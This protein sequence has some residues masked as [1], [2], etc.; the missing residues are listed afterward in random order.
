MYKLYNQAKELLEQEY[1]KNFQIV[2]ESD[3]H[4][5][6]INEKIRH[7]LQ[8]SGAG[9]GILRHEAYFQNR[10][11]EFL[12]ICRSAIVLHDIFRFSE[13]SRWFLSGELSDHGVEGATMLKNLPPFDDIRI[14]LAIKHHGHLVERFYQD[15]EYIALKDPALK[16]DIEHIHFA[17]R[18]ADKIANWQILTGEFEA[19]R[20]VWLPYPQDMSS[21]QSRITPEAWE[22]FIN[23]NPVPREFKMTN[24]DMLLSVLSWLFDVNYA[25]SIF[26]CRRLNLFNKYFKLFEIIGVDKEKCAQ[27]KNTVCEYLAGRFKVNDLKC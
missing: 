24:A 12:D 6:Y 14:T 11:E 13:V 20:P 22:S 23:K 7:S 26:Y 19:M 8:V 17:V 10:S 3:F 15:E 4:R 16:R 25:Y 2:K 18:D 5:A 21:A 1:N 27:I 9:N